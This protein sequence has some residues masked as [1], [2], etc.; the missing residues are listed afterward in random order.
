M[1]TWRLAL[2]IT[3][4]AALSALLTWLNPVAPD[5]LLVT[6]AAPIRMDVG[7][8]CVR[9]RIFARRT[10]ALDVRFRELLKAREGALFDMTS[11]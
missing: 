5:F 1:G 8:R 4:Q 3:L 6:S 11:A 10:Y 7:Q 9:I 2:K